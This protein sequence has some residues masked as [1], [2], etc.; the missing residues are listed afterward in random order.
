MHNKDMKT[1]QAKNEHVKKKN[2]AI[3]NIALLLLFVIF[4]TSA[5]Y[6]FKYFYSSY[7]SERAF[8]DLKDYV[9][10]DI[11]IASYSDAPTETIQNDVAG[12]A[13]EFIDI[14]GRYVLKKLANLYIENKDFVGWITIE[15][16]NIDYPVMQSLYDEEYY[17]DK[18][19]YRNPNSSGTLFADTSSD[20]S[21][22]SDVVI[23]YGHNMKAG[24]MFQ[25]LLKY[26][27]ESFYKDHKYINFDTIYGSGRY[28]V[29]A[30]F[31]DEIYD[32]DY[33]GIKYYD[34]FD[35]QS[36]AEY[37]AYVSYCR[38]KTPYKIDI[39]AE[40][41]DKLLCLSTCAYHSDN[42]RYV[43]LAKRCK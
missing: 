3:Y 15:G 11:I 41:G 12:T 27:D 8:N 25:N 18:D 32:K 30:A 22:P 34:F 24:T 43:I 38:S 14:D 21:K 33:T 28:E 13:E 36:E 29:I 4:C 31:R 20:I 37:M 17:I 9:D 2:K 35:A 23:I 7:K 42:G 39:T 10:A 26:E 19:F 40:Y 16:T 6:L 1:K 5:I